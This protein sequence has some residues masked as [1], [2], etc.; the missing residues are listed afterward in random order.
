ML[1]YINLKY[2][3]LPTELLCEY[4]IEPNSMY[5][6]E[7][8]AG[9][10]AAESSIGTWTDIA[11][12]NPTIAAK[13]RPT[14]YDINR[15]K[16]IVKIAYPQELF[17]PGN[18]SQ[19]LSSIA[20]NIFGMKALNNLRLIDINFPKGILKSF[21]GPR[22]GI[23][24]IKKLTKIKNR[25]ILGTIVKPKVG[26]NE[27][28]HAQVAYHAWVGGLD[29]VKDDENLS[30]MLFNNFDIRI[31][32]TLKQKR[33]AEKETGEKKIYMPNI[34]AE[35]LEMI[36]R[37]NLVKQNGGEYIMIDILTCGWAGLQTIRNLDLGLVIHAHRAGHA[38]LTRN[39]LHGI[40][41][42]TIAKIARLIGCDQ[43]HIG[44]VVGK[45]DGNFDEVYEIEEEIEQSFITKNKKTHTL[46]QKWQNIKPT[47]A[48]ASGGLHPGHLPK[49]IK[50]LGKNIVAQ[51]G[52][53]CHGHPDG[54]LAGA[55]AIRQA[56]E[57]TIKN[58]PLRTYAKKHYELLRA[59]EKFGIK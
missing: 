46:E 59:I 55:R 40:S 34:T 2:K 58:I 44:T 10:I 36:R 9:F 12:M 15:Q 26:L 56:C 37:A 31:K 53:G 57:A 32:E 39:R 41:M 50:L 43:L 35:T 29:I 28:E 16:K 30:S 4:Y 5:S 24:G 47:F 48:V 21:K 8:V 1:E 49:L 14:V 54:T 23:K 13:L 27:K 3:P 20:G 17:E 33:K 11:T 6:I 52:G 7:K 22:F 19:I 18:M 42:L 51:F 25:P 38:A 45:M